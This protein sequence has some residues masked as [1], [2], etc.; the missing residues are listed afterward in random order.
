MTTARTTTAVPVRLRYPLLLGIGGGG[1][2]GLLAGLALTA[3]GA[4]PGVVEP[5][6]AVVVGLPLSRLALDLSAVVTVG[7]SLLPKL[8]GLDRP[9]RT[10]G[11]L[12]LARRTAVV[13][14][15]VWLVAALVSL[16]LETADE[17]AG[18]TV[19]LG[20]VTE[21]VRQ[22]ASGQGL[23][24]VAGCAVVYLVIAVLALVRGEAVPVEL[25]IT[26]AMFSLLPLPVTG[27]A[28]MGGNLHDLSMISM[29]LHVVGAVVWT[30][31][32]LAVVL[33]VATNRGLLAEA[34]PRYSKLATICVF[35]TAGTG[36]FNGWFMLWDTPGIHWYLAVFDTG[37]GR[38]LLLK[39]FCV[40][41][42]GLLGAHTRF[43]LMPKIE[44]RKNTALV[45]WAA[46]E[47]VVMGAA[48]GLA[49]VLVRAPVVGS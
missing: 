26:V 45:T 27:H 14:A 9:K 10:A 47:V 31:G 11:T 28:A 43:K 44:Q 21:Y 13:S 24:I 8:V 35:L 41:A 49:A 19:T 7:V 34:L 39:A 17:N 38:I 42:A 36:V 48:F 30:G 29:E 18:Q 46:L 37:Y 25:R 32:L 22:I 15:T 6:T 12:L 23:L 20:Q 4:V 1:L 3:A 2:I 5:G 33:L 40:A 16:V